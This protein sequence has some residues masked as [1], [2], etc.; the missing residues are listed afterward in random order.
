MLVASHAHAA[1]PTPPTPNALSGWQLRVDTGPSARF[2][3]GGESSTDAWA[4]GV[5]LAYAFHHGVSID[6][7]Y[8]DLGASRVSTTTPLQTASTG[9]RYSVPLRVRPFGELRCGTAFDITGAFFASAIALGVEVPFS[10]FLRGE[11][12]IRDWLVPDSITLRSIV[13]FNIGLTVRFVQ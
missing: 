4:F 8:E 6:A 7:R 9:I 11:L 2:A 12:S 1:S 10:R 3:S 13:T 5:S